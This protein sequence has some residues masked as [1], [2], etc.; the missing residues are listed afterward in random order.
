MPAT[1]VGAKTQHL[2]AGWPEL[3]G[4]TVVAALSTPVLLVDAAGLVCHANPA[5]AALLGKGR[6]IDELFRD[7]RMGP[8]FSGWPALIAATLRSGEAARVDAY[9]PGRADGPA[10]V[11][12][13]TFVALPRASATGDR[14]AAVTIEDVSWRAGL[15]QRL[16]T[17]ERLVSLGKLAARVA[18]ELNNPLDGILRYINLSLRLLK[19]DSHPKLKS[20]L[21]ESRTGLMRMTQIIRDL[22]EF[23]RASH[24]QFDIA[25]INDVVEQA[26]REYSAK[27]AEHRVIV[28]VDYQDDHLPGVRG[29]RLYQVCCN[30]I[31]NA[32]EAMPDGG[33]LSITTGRMGDAVIIRVADTGP[34]LPADAA[35]LFEPFFS[36]KPAGQGTGLGLAICREY[37]EDM[38]GTIEAANAEDG[39]AVFTVRVPMSACQGVEEGA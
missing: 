37:L 16:A 17:H 9:L 11:L 4:A 27:A 10:R 6:R 26:I 13:L 31:K 5:A 21:D 3:D 8:A 30:L 2:I 35:R 25:R 1:D 24:G 29:G 38:Q 32:I 39:G 23:S 7:A 22:L 15:E 20:Y 28:A 12:T 14:Y 19:D 33:R 18:H 34:G 36:T